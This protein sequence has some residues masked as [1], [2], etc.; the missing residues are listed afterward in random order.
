LDEAEIRAH[1]EQ[2]YRPGQELEQ[3]P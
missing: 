1:L 2:E 3:T